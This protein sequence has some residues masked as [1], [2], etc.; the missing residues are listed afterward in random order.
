MLVSC[1][2]LSGNRH[3]D[4]SAFT[5]TWDYQ[6][7][8]ETE[9]SEA[10]LHVH[11]SA[12]YWMIHRVW[13]GKYQLYLTKNPHMRYGPQLHPDLA[14]CPGAGLTVWP[15]YYFVPPGVRKCFET[16]LRAKSAFGIS[17]WEVYLPQ[18]WVAAVVADHTKMVFEANGD[19]IWWEKWD[20]R[21]R[22]WIKCLLLNLLPVQTLL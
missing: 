11:K 13:S 8:K 1:Q 17:V 21:G 9:S 6:S 3:L 19:S 12:N 16:I 5:A 14:C 15:Q 22:A 7:F 10:R 4:I 18:N 20:G 2:G